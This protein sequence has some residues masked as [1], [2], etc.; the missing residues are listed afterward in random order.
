M[1]DWTTTTTDQTSSRIATM[2]AYSAS[3]IGYWCFTLP[4]VYLYDFYS[5]LLLFM[6]TSHYARWVLTPTKF[7]RP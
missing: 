7:L 1:R 4:D 5:I 3:I 6:W 2:A